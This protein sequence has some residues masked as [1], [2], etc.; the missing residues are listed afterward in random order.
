MIEL[1]ILTGDIT[2]AKR[3]SEK[4]G[5]LRGSITH[6][7]GN[8]IGMLGELLVARHIQAELNP[9]YDYDLLKDGWRID[10]KTKRCTSPPRPEYE[11]SIAD[12]NTRQ[13]CDY[14]VFSRILNDASQAWL[15]GAIKKEEYFRKA[16]FRKEGELDPNS[17]LGWT[18][19]ADCYNLP[20]S[21]LRRVGHERAAC[22]K[23][24]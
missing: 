18:F 6:G 12:F 11:C 19:K 3:L 2:E 1:P 20:I 10:V 23:S 9:T 4:L 15:L 8:V 16:T 13:K 7:E 24:M 21:E 14:Y 5:S 17:R 22:L